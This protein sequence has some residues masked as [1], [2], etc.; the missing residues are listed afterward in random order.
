[1]KKD[2]SGIF[3]SVPKLLQAFRNTY[4]NDS[5]ISEG[6]L[7]QALET[8]DCLVLDDIGAENKTDWAT[9]K[10]FN[11]ID[12]RQG[13]STIFTSNLDMK[14]LENPKTGVGPRNFSRIMMNANV[15]KVFGPDHRKG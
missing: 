12:S 2:Y 8:V 6:Q 1:M 13:K 14:A 10:L 5:E 3:V 7:L 15:Q 11:I 4:N 9:D